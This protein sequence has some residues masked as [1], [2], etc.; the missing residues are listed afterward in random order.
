MATGKT[1]HCPRC[2]KPIPFKGVYH[3][4]FGAEGFLYCDKDATVLTFSAHDEEFGRLVPD[5]AP[6]PP[7]AG[8]NLTPKEQRLI[9]QH[10]R[11]CPCGGRFS[12][13]N[14]PLCPFCGSSIEKLVDSIHYLV[15]QKKIDGDKSKIWKDTQRQQENRGRF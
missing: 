15:L 10:L 6:W 3:A 1:F 11:P 14:K 8:G 7:C 4:G 5:K 12:F 9:E 2:N 13:Q